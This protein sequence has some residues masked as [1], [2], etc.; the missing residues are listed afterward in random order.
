VTLLIATGLLREARILA[1]PGVIVIAGGGD[2]ERLEAALEAAAPGASALLSIGLAG[3]LAPHLKP[4]NWVISDTRFQSALPG[5]TVG[6]VAG[7][8]AI[9]ATALEKRTLAAS[10][11]AVAVDME[12]HIAARVAARRGLPFAVLR[13]ISD[14]AGQDLPHAAQVGMNPDGSMAIGAVLR[15]L[16]GNLSQFPALITTAVNAERAF[17]SLSRGYNALARLGLGDPDLGK[18]FFDMR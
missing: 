4:G 5:A 10:T 18:R 17:R 12:S 14:S 7:S 1:R 3:A 2:S 8:N 15:S 13:V 9:A 16:A 6:K 11:G